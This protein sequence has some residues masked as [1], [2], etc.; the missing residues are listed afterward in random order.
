M[1]EK[2]TYDVAALR[3]FYTNHIQALNGVLGKLPEGLRG[4]LQQL[5]DRLNTQLEGLKPVD[6]APADKDATWALN[7]L[8]DALVR[9]QEYASGV[10]ARLEAMATALSTKA[11]EFNGL[12]ESLTKDYLKKDLVPGL[13]DKARQEG[14]DSVMP[15]VIA[16]RKG[17]VELAGLPLP[18]DT[19]L[20][21][22]ADDFG[23][24]L[25]GAKANLATLAA[26]GMKL[27][28]KGDAWVKQTVWLGTAEFAGQMQVIDDLMPKTAAPD[29]LLGNP[30][31]EPA[32]AEK[33]SR[34]ITIG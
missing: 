8:A 17:Q 33:G 22:K 5:K 19:V 29:P 20:S 25:D 16:L 11:T 14:I 34:K 12:Q 9:I 30:V 7:G 26:K 31:A 1:S 23:K 13:T 6:P 2:T 21:A 15:S 27:G 18:A 3:G 4:E 28:G 10:V 24:A 32:K